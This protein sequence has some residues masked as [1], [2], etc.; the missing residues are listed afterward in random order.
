MTQ[1]TTAGFIPQQS[2]VSGLPFI[3]ANNGQISVASNT[4]LTIQPGQFRDSLNAVDIVVGSYF[5]DPQSTP[6]AL[7]VNAAA[8]GL[9]GLDTGTFAASTVYAVH[10]IYDTTLKLVS[11]YMLSLSATAPTLPFGY[12]SFRRIG[13]AIS[14]SSTHFL[15]L[16]QVGNNSDRTYYYDTLQSVLSGGTATS[17]TAVDLSAFVPTMITPVTFNY[18]YT[19]SSATNLASLRATGSSATT[20]NLIRAS[21]AAAMDNQITIMTGIS[22]SKAEIDYKVVSSDTLSLL[23]YS[24]KDSL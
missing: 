9:N 24:F 11:G 18:I 15:P 7:T 3:Y 20:V 23:V 19:P 16:T 10:A 13:W 17:F 22:S 2:W 5:G 4:T 8:T 1:Q 21:A 12:S 14:D 6:A